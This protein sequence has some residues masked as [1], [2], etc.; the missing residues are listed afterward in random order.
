MLQT[1]ILPAAQEKLEADL[2]Q[3]AVGAWTLCL[4]PAN[5]EEMG[6]THEWCTSNTMHNT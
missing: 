2:K 4:H 3:E 6:N 5:R 1:S